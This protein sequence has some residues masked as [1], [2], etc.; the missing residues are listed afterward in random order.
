MALAW[1]STTLRAANPSAWWLLRVLAP[2]AGFDQFC[3]VYGYF[4]WADDIVDAPGRDRG[5]VE[6][7]VQAQREAMRRFWS[8]AHPA[9]VQPTASLGERAVFSA[10]RAQ[11]GLRVAVDGM[12]DA[13]EFDSRRGPEPV[14]ALQIDA[15]VARIG[16]AYAAG[17]ALCLGV[18]P[19][20]LGSVAD[21]E[22]RGV[23]R[24]MCAL[25]RAATVVHQ[26]RDVVVDRELG[27]CNVPIEDL[28]RLAIDFTTAT[29]RDLAP[30]VR[31]RCQSVLPVF[32]TEEQALGARL[33]WRA[34][35]VFRI[36]GRRYARLARELCQAR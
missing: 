10:L 26:A 21:A 11:P 25:S 3:R 28:E 27:Y 23:R 6:E 15:Q 20:E 31:E 33:P 5:S 8:R 18:Q 36:Y 19:A 16:D 2:R 30:W 1:A 14:P 32:T 29:S 34:R 4:R 24:S 35:W 17:L 9:G 12:W 7:F 22:A 13:L